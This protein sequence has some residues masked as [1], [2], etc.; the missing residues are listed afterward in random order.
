M[1]LRFNTP[2]QKKWINVYIGPV[3]DEISST[4]IKHCAH[5]IQNNKA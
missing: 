2:L 3:G 1:H 5:T 4:A